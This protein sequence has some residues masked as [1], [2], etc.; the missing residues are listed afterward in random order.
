MWSGGVFSVSYDVTKVMGGGG[1]GQL[2]KQ[3]T[4]N[5]RVSRLFILCISL[6]LGGKYMEFCISLTPV[7][8]KHQ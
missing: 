7:Q 5:I 2:L 3:N 6:V 1:G 8:H 4:V